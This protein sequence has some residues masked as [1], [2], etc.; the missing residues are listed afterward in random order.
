MGF[1]RVRR[2]P[3]DDDVKAA[4]TPEPAT[5]GP[6]L[7][8]DVDGALARTDL[9]WEGAVQLLLASPA[10]VL[11]MVTALL[12]GRPA[13]KRWIGQRAS[14]NADDVPLDEAVL[15]LVKTARAEGRE[16]VLA[17]A[18]VELLIEPLARRV[19][20]S[21]YLCSDG[22][23]NAAGRAKLQRIRERWREFDY[24]GNTLADL[25]VWVGARTAYAVRPSGRLVR[26]ASQSGIRLEPL[27]S[28]HSVAR[29]FLRALRPHQWAKNLLLPLP[30]LAA[31]LRW[32]GAL[33]FRML[34][35][36]LAFS[37]VSSAVYLLNDAADIPHDR[38]HPR[39]RL[40]PIAAGLLSLPHAFAG[41][42]M[43]MVGAASV[44]VLL[45]SGFAMALLAYLVFTVLYSMRL[46]HMLI[47][48]VIV[49]ALLY[50]LRVLA[51][52]ELAQVVLSPW[53]SAFSV[54]LFLS[55]ALMKRTIEL[56]ALADAVSPGRPYR[57]EDLPVLAGFG[58]GATAVAAL[59]YCLYI[60]TAPTAALYGRPDLLWLGLPLLLYWMGRAWILANRGS[61]DDDPVVFA[62]RDRAA[63][64]VGVLFLAVLLAAAW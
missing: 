15:R 28:R 4:A 54:F 11:G 38:R 17:S 57:Q 43:L 55:L 8:I 48:D 52:A 5:A 62:L 53:F 27:G 49:L 60:S 12:R 47:L 36:F 39:K 58:A 18:A 50:A 41:A 34:A 51:G 46:K 9:H 63:W 37:A 26:S 2:D 59:V 30:A 42:A 24:V 16:V 21:A 13:L 3:P 29:A 25:D 14:Y 44:T 1:G 20:A 31:H 23:A 56:R 33:T 7:V 61:M 64:A 32:D 45:P 10:A 19:G 22:V 35:G 40:R 6:A